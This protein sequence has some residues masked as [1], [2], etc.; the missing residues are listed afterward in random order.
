MAYAH[1]FEANPHWL[2]REQGQRIDHIPGSDGL[3]LVGTFLAQLRDPVGFTRRMA[4]RH[5]PV[6]RTR[7]YGQRWVHLLGADANEL[8]LHN[9]DGAFGS[10]QGWGPMLNLLLPR[11]LMLMDGETHR[12]H[13]RTLSAAFKPAPMRRYAGSIAAGIAER[14]ERWRGREILFYPEIKQLSLDLAADAFLGIPLGPEAER[15]NRAFVDIVDATVGVARIPLPFT[16]MAKG[17]KG[18]AYLVD[19]F[20]REVPKRR[21][22][23]GDDLFSQ[24]CRARDE[25]GRLLEV[26]QIA[27]HMIFLMMAAHDT[28]TSSA[29]AL[30][31][32]LGRH[33]EWQDRLREE[34]AA[35]GA[36][37]LGLDELDRFP[38]AEMAFKETL[39]LVAPVPSMP[40][41][42]LKDVEFAGY[43]I[44]AGTFVSIHPEYPH[45]MPEHWPEP[46]RFDP[47]RFEP[48]QVRARHKYAWVPFGG[49]A[50]M[51]L[52]LH[53]A[54]MQTKL[55]VHALL[56]RSR[57]VL[58]EGAGAR[59]QVWPI[60]KPKDGLPVRLEPL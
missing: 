21:E 5:G 22:G 27:D 15:I 25:D 37:P 4:A 7:S 2:P 29:T 26:A 18:R 41:R 9:R 32:Q 56:G 13:R 19:L 24:V 8:V 51:C 33:P 50:H 16:R 12:A 52:G 43:R 31:W 20:A 23:D 35:A 60:P 14:V 55:L 17:V 11:G 46:E 58:P 47:L 39:R 45:S 54:M 59:W 28:I 38:L 1:T 34:A 57:I 6:Y 44:P 40:R 48:D 42:A 10:E 30:V 3:P 53:F 49:G 36:G